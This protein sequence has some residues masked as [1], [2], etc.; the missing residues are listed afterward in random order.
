MCINIINDTENKTQQT[1]KSNYFEIWFK[2]AMMAAWHE[3]LISILHGDL[4]NSLAEIQYA[5]GGNSLLNW[6]LRWLYQL[7]D[8]FPLIDEPLLI[9]GKSTGIVFLK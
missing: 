2:V 9:R 3:Q 5:W 6:V 1:K 8:V 4:L 7:D